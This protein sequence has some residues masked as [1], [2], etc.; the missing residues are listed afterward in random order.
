[1]HPGFCS[2]VLI[3]IRQFFL[4]K[5][6]QQTMNRGFQLAMRAMWVVCIAIVGW[7]AWRDREELTYYIARANYLAL[8]IALLWYVFSLLAVAIG[9]STIMRMFAKSQ[10]LWTN[11]LVYFATLAARRLPGTLWYIGGRLALYKRFGIPQRMVAMA[12]GV[13]LVVL[14]ITGSLIGL[15]FVPTGLDLPAHNLFP[16]LGIAALGVIVLNPAVL[17]LLAKK[18]GLDHVRPEKRDI[19]VSFIAYSTM[20]TVSG[21]MVSQVVAAF[22]PLDGSEVLLVIGYWAVAGTAGLL[23]VFLPSSFGATD[24][25]LALLLSRFMPIS[26]GMIVSILV[27]IMTT[28]FEVLLSAIASLFIR[29]TPAL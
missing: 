13:E 10:S 7:A 20:W 15:V 23:T 9:W 25:T 27:R 22:R 29:E 17:G 2:L 16:L 26:L 18:M 21:I 12:S 6:S 1:M 3:K 14:V 24:I 11:A 28:L 19:A 5:V 8:A 4:S